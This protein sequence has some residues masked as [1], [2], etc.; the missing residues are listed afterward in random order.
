MS[1][2]EALAAGV[3]IVATDVGGVSETID[4]NGVLLPSNPTPEEIAAAIKRICIAPE[5]EWKRLSAR[6]FTLWKE[7]FDV[8]ANKNALLREL[9]L[10]NDASDGFDWKA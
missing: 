6:S 3:P 9:R 4:G 8:G 2:Q 10:T 7:R 5:S 1:I